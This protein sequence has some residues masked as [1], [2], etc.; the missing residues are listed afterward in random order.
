MAMVVFIFR[1]GVFP[2]K[3]PR[4][5]LFYKCA[6]G[7]LPW[8][9]FRVRHCWCSRRRG[10]YR[11]FARALGLPA[12]TPHPGADNSET[13]QN[14]NRPVKVKPRRREQHSQQTAEQL[15]TM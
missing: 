10:P 12:E 13:C 14:W 2:G 8:G 5:I 1:A 7:P 6:L 9:G 15:L 4:Q 11:R 3:T